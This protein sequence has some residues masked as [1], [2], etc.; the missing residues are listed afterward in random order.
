MS[1]NYHVIIPCAGSGSRFGLAVPKQYYQILDKTVLEWTLNSFIELSDAIKSISVIYTA[2]D[3]YILAYKLKYPTIN[4][5]AVGGQSRAESVLNGLHYLSNKIAQPNDWVM[6]H[7]A[8][9]CLI[10][11]QDI[12]NLLDRV[13]ETQIGGILAIAA[14]DTIKQVD[15]SNLNIEQTI[16][17]NKIYLAQTPQVFKHQELLDALT[18]INLDAITDE[19][20]AI[21]QF[22]KSSQVVLT[23]YPNFKIT[24]PQ[25][26]LLAEFIL[27][28]RL[29][30][31]I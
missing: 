7:D 2:E 28:Q 22:G 14:T 15:Q 27:Q 25:D 11:K 17:R 20:S 24:Y 31:G 16:D 1:N 23:Q 8:A 26:I 13:K 4:F 29:E 9:R 30:R 5:I 10:D 18:Q 12:L 21:E 3:N 19:S 6:V